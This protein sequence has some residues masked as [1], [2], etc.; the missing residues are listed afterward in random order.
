MAK[1]LFV[2]GY[3]A[4]DDWARNALH[5]SD[6]ESSDAVWIHARSEAEA[7]DAGCAYAQRRVS[8]LF[9]ARPPSA[10]PGWIE[11]GYAHWI[12]HRPLDRFT[13][14]ALDLLPEIDATP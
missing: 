10:F 7:L 4:P 1:Y 11:A 12:E 13:G 6:D 8:A 14:V 9:A 2:Y 3:E 5:G